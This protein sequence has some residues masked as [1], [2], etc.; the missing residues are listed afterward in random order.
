MTIFFEKVT[1]NVLLFALTHNKNSCSFTELRLVLK[2]REHDSK[3]VHEISL[4]FPRLFIKRKYIKIGFKNRGPPC[5]F[6]SSKGQKIK[7][8]TKIEQKRLFLFTLVVSFFWAFLA[9]KLIYKI[10]I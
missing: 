1:C 4:N 10:S 8:I 2:L 5:Y 7:D 3:L 6:L 9:Q